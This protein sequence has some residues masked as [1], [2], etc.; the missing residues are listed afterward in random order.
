MRDF[1]AHNFSHNS[2]T[3]L[4]HIQ[5]Y[6][7]HLSHMQLCHARLCQ[8]HTHTALSHTTLSNNSFTYNSLKLSTLHHFLCFSCL[9]RTT[10]TTVSDYVK[11]LTCA[12]IRSFNFDILGPE[13]EQIQAAVDAGCASQGVYLEETGQEILQFLRSCCFLLSIK[14]VI[15]YFA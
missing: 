3:Q 1:V 14:F 4:A 8:T 11:K 6:R 15:L 5:L 10:S 7:V 12:V 2:H 9:L 13:F